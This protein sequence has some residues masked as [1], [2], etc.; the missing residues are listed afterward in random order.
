M[1]E[2]VKYQNNMAKEW[3]AFIDSAHNGTIFHKQKFLSY[4]ID[5]NFTD[6]SLLFKKRGKIIAVLPA[7]I[8]KRGNKKILFSHPGASFGGLV[9]QKLSFIDCSTIIEIIE[10]FCKKNN[11][12]EIFIIQTPL[13]FNQHQNNEVVDYCLRKSQ[14]DNTENYLSS[15]LLIQD[16]INN[17]LKEIARNK[18]RSMNYYNSLIKENKIQFK[19]ADNFQEFYPILIENKKKHN[20]KPTHSLEELEKLKQL[21]PDDILQLMILNNQHSIG[22]MTVFKANE[23]SL[24]L[25]YTMFDY[26]YN[27]I[28]PITLLMHYILKWSKKHH[29]R[30][31]DY[32][33]SHQPNQKDP[34]RPNISLIKFKEEFGCFS[35]IRNTYKKSF[36]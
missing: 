25:F 12:N 35:S 8:E 28:Q 11:F 18:K 26:S 27:N 23:T 16:N 10:A 20:A 34:L 22:G 17:Q 6:S 32:G 9:Y 7:A 14:Y 5:R 3:D 21:F 31:I 33:I 36:E 1:I 19:W 2:T 13:V 30:L 24:I 15:V 4:H 29:I